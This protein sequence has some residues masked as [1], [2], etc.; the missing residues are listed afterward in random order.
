[1]NNFNQQP[2][3]GQNTPPQFQP[4]QPQYRQPPQYNY[5]YNYNYNYAPKIPDTF[6]KLDFVFA[7]ISVV[8]GI[9]FSKFVLFNLSGFF[10]TAFFIVMLICAYVF[11]RKK[12]FEITASKKLFWAV[13][14][15]FTIPFSITANMFIKFL[16][17]CFLIVCGVYWVFSS[18]R[19]L[20]FS[21][22]AFINV[23]KAVFEVPFSKFGACPKA[24]FNTNSKK[25][26][27]NLVFAIIGI[28]CAFPFT[29]FIANL[30]MQADE[31]MEKLLNNIFGNIFDNLVSNVVIFLIGIPIAL[32][33][34]GMLYGNAKLDNG[35]K[36]VSDESVEVGLNT[37]K[38]IPNAFTFA[39]VTPV[40]VLYA[41]YFAIQIRYFVS[42]FMNIL[43]ENF[44]YANYARQGFF[45][46]FGVAFI[47]ALVILLMNI[48]SKSS[49][50]EKNTG[51]KI[52][53]VIIC[54]FT[55][56]LI[57]SALSKMIMYM[58]IYGLTPLRLYTSWFMVLLALL[59]IATILKQFAPKFSIVKSSAAIFVIMFALL[60]FSCPDAI[61]A[62][63]NIEMY[64]A[65]KTKELDIY[66]LTALSDDSWVVILDNES[67]INEFN[68]TH[69]WIDSSAD[70]DREKSYRKEQLDNFYQRMSVS[71]QIVYNK[72]NAK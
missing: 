61:I 28:I 39:F 7:L 42:A 24:L 43:P 21:K 48:F 52:Y 62:K 71:S 51:V 70:L 60:S 49:K 23:F 29:I 50:S 37:A 17:V 10:T 40:C 41:L 30:L 54:F 14:L 53:S 58:N 31:N 38:F 3:F 45:E 20:P 34:F 15:L 16:L 26:S 13:M 25:G 4:Q 8:L 36:T 11:I 72:L 9:C 1:M 47:N 27:K 55:L 57:A 64:K 44:T 59:F 2:Q 18:C 66:T 35:I 5:N 19:K 12:G 22:A 68:N 67:V 46:L 6:S 33:L 63:T 32:Y 65:G 56:V 69:K